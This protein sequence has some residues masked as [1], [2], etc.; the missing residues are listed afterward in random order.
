MD[1][2]I[3]WNHIND[4]EWDTLIS[5]VPQSNIL[6]TSY[7]A[8][9]ASKTYNHKS[10]RGVIYINENPA[11]I[12]QMME[13]GILFNM[14]HA[15]MVDR[16]PLWFDGFGGAAHIQLF[17]KELDKQF[18]NRLGRKRRIL[19]EIESSPTADALLKQTGLTKR[20][21]QD[22][23][24]TLWWNLKNNLEDAR[25]TLS[26]SW[27]GSLKKAEKSDLTLSW[28]DSGKFYPWLKKHYTID[29]AKRGYDGISP[30]LL[31]NI[32]QISTSAPTMLIGKA[33]KEGKDIAAIMLLLHGKSATYQ[34][35]WTSDEGRQFCAH[36]L[37][38]WDAR[39]V[40]QQY[41]ID[42]IDLGGINDQSD[43]AAMGIK[44]FKMGTGAQPVRYIGHYS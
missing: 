15:I 39:S 4:H 19:P 18:P 5:N 37:L 7:Y 1:C 42:H 20:D 29:K 22:G 12:V 24:Q 38:L 3:K 21:N 43:A 34:I 11:G 31:D 30:Q 10:R 14:L 17:F 16:G 41:D 33:S 35:G 9:A 23:Y 32:A 25:T 44:K 27:L 8:Q 40:L 13:N 2:T 36:H 28:D 26:K 6:Q